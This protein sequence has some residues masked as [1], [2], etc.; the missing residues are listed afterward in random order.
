MRI[1]TAHDLTPSSDV[2]LRRAAGLAAQGG[3]ELRVVHALSPGAPESAADAARDRLEAALEEVA[4][5]QTRGET[6][7]SIRICRADAA[8]II[9]SQA[10]AYEADLIVLGGHGSPRLRDAMF[11]TTAGHVARRAAPPVLIVQNDPG[12][13]YRKI[14]IA[15]DDESAEQVLDLA[16]GFASPEEIH[17]VHAFGNALQAVIG[18]VDPIEDVRTEQDVLVARLR[19]KLEATGRKAP[20]IDT[21]VEEGDEMD[22]IM[23]AWNKIEP[24]LVVM[25]THGRTGMAHFLHGSLAESLLLGCPSD[26][27]IIRTGSER[28]GS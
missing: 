28:Q 11:G 10:A 4:G 2:A 19:R 1:L 27:L 21:I 5:G 26:M 17:V 18:A 13:P 15:V 23:R 16:L 14:M 20:R 22:V 24:D 25:G 3:A 9:L 6:G 7:L 8:D 12:R